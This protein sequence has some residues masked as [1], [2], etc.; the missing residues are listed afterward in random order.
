[1]VWSEIGV[2]RLFLGPE[3]EIIARIKNQYQFE[4]FDSN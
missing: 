3:K 2:K 4:S 1:M